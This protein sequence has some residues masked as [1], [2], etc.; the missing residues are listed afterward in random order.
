MPTP[1]IDAH[2]HL[3]KYSAKEYDWIDDSMK[4]IRR[5]FLPADL[6]KEITRAHIDGVVTVQARQT[7]EETDW[8]LG[9]AKQNAFMRGVVGWVPLL[10]PN[11]A[12]PLEKYAAQPKFKAVRHVLQ[13]E[14]DPNYMLRPEFQRGIAALRPLKLR[15]D[16]LIFEKQLPQ[17]IQLV[18]RNPNQVFVLDHIAKPRIK[19][20]ALSPWTENIRKIAERPNVYCKLSGMVTEGDTQRWTAAD[21]QPYFEV[22]LAAFGPQKLM[23]GSDWPVALVGTQYVRW[24]ETVEGAIKR[25]SLAE[26]ER[27]MGGTAVEA[28]KL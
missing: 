3:W 22:V 10:D 21:L 15:Y 28:Y 27:I 12:G 17:A 13:G 2:H 5:D 7:L 26:R 4:A 14:S 8:L 11:V 24:V 18:D 19:E 25:L 6:Q 1:R 23:F 9:M 20:H 16:I